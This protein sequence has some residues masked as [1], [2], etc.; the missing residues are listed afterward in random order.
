MLNFF[1]TT[2]RLKDKIFRKSNGIDVVLRFSSKNFV[3]EIRAKIFFFRSF[4]YVD[5]RDKNLLRAEFYWP[6]RYFWTFFFFFCHVR[7]SEV[8]VIL[9]SFWRIF[10]RAVWVVYWWL[11]R[12]TDHVFVVFD[13]AN[14]FGVKVCFIWLQVIWIFNTYTGLKIRIMMRCFKKLIFFEMW[15]RAARILFWVNKIF[16]RFSPEIPN[17]ISTKSE[18]VYIWGEKNFEVSCKV[19]I[20]LIFIDIGCVR[21]LKDVLET[22]Q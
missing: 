4:R 12:L 3:L 22:P 18:K 10:V 9:Y 8:S 6:L 15:Y 16:T 19:K 14:L 20:I 11:S 1:P 2:R 17:S 5:F 13:G 21:N 7:F